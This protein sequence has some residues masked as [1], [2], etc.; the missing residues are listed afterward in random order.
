MEWG[1]LLSYL[2]QSF[3]C[4][5]LCLFALMVLLASSTKEPYPTSSQPIIL[6]S[7]F[8][9]RY[10]SDIIVRRRPTVLPFTDHPFSR[11]SVRSTS[12]GP[13]TEL[14]GQCISLDLSLDQNGEASAAT[15]RRLYQDGTVTCFVFP[16]N[17][18]YDLHI[19]LPSR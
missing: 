12:P 5:S 8:Y 17:D 9:A 7:F 15:L 11:I 14:S 16:S 10:D 6:R 3:H 19:C 18:D 1:G 13:S 2:S 4:T